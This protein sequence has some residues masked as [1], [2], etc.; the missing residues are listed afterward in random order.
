MPARQGSRRAERPRPPPLPIPE[1]MRQRDVFFKYPHVLQIL[2]F[3]AISIGCILLSANIASL[4]VLA[5]GGAGSMDTRASL[6]FIQGFSSIGGF[7][8]PALWLGWM[9]KAG[10]ADFLHARSRAKTIPVL[11]GIAFLVLSAPLVSALQGWGASW[12]PG[13]GLDAFFSQKT[14]QSEWLIERLLHVDSWGS[15]LAAFLVIAV[16][17]GVC[18]EFLFRGGLQNLLA[19]WFKNPHAAVWVAAAIFS[20]VHVDLA[21]FLPRCLLGGILGYAYMYSGSIWVPVLLHMANNGVS[22]LLEFCYH[23]GYSKL[24]PDVLSQS[25]GPEWIIA[26]IAGLVFFSIFI[27]RYRRLKENPMDQ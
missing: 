6:L 23:K 15:F 10:T 17:A 20:A 26:S 4:L 24:D 7:L 21:G 13:P 14:A 1:N 18:E 19:E 8:F 16:I 11:T 3:A 12:H 9:K 22:C 2:Y 25:L 5:I 27:F